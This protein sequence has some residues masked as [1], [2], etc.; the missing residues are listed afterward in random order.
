MDHKMID[1]LMAMSRDDLIKFSTTAI[2]TIERLEGFNKLF[3]EDLE[4]SGTVDVEIIWKWR[5]WLGTMDKERD[6]WAQ[7]ATMMSAENKA[8]KAENE[9]MIDRCEEILQMLDSISVFVNVQVD[10]NKPPSFLLGVIQRVKRSIDNS[11]SA[12]LEFFAD[13]PVEVSQQTTGPLE[14]AANE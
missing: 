2:E 3:K 6:T 4:A 1:G 8:L 5:E 7:L 10:A 12:L 11:K 13:E 9:K 14:P